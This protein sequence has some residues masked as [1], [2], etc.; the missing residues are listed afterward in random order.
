MQIIKVRLVSSENEKGCEN[1]PNEIL[2][3]LKE[4]ECSENGKPIEFDKISF[5]EIHINLNDL[6]ETDYLIFENS[7]EAFARNFKTFFI[8]GDHSIDYPIVKAFC[9]TEKNPLLIVFDAHVDCDSKKPPNRNWL[10][11]L[12]IDSEISSR[13]VVLISSRNLSLDEI[14]FIKEAEITWIKMEIL[15]ENIDEVCDIVMERARSASGFYV[16][17]DMDCADPSFVPG[18]SDLEPG[19]LTSRE[20]VYFLKRLSLLENFKGADIVEVN[21]D[22]DSN[23]ITTK[24]AA[25]LL[26]EMI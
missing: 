8:G 14:S 18:T 21:P 26:A 17:V 2:K 20:L 4:I 9:K 5:E 23:E 19:G 13:K 10:K 16:S 12:I 22:K 3:N 7:K 25:R 15:Q 6:D 1:A 11:K 24:L